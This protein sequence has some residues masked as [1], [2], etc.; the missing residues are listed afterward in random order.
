[1]PLAE[2]AICTTPLEKTSEALGENDVGV[3]VS[4]IRSV[5]KNP[6]PL[7]V[8]ILKHA[9]RERDDKRTKGYT[10]QA[11]HTIGRKHG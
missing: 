5:R 9:E 8:H 6:E 3:I 2:S 11:W 1:M 4:G 10:K 7:R